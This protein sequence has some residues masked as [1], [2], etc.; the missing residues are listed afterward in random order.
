MYE[1]SPLYDF[2]IDMETHQ[3]QEC[4]VFRVQSK[5]DLNSS[6]RDDIVIDQMTTWF[7]HYNF[8]ILGRSYSLS[9]SAGVY[10]FDVQMEVELAKFGEWLVPTLIRYNGNWG[11]IFRRKERGVFT[12]TLFDFSGD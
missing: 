2:S 3:G 12:A 1:M 9:Y 10:N 5:K 8:E 7:N 4:Y 11:L 6:Q